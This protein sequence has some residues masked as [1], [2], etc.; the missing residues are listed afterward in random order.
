MTQTVTDVIITPA[1]DGT[2]KPGDTL[3]LSVELVGKVAP[4]TA[5]VSVK[6]NAVVW[7]VSAKDSAEE[8]A[9][10]IELSSATRVTDDNVLHVQKTG[11]K[12]GNVLHITGTTVYVNPSGETT[13]YTKAIDITIA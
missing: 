8:N 4:V 7:S 5:G 12:A 9:A 10:P 6:P 2:V 13:K 3:Q 11:V 1:T